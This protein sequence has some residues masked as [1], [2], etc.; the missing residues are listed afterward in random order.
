M[1]DSTTAL[2][3]AIEGYS[4]DNRGKKGSEN[5]QAML[6]RVHSSLKGG[7]GPIS[8][9][10]AVAQELAGENANRSQSAEKTNAPG[11]KGTNE[12]NPK[13]F[14]GFGGKL[15]ASNQEVDAQDKTPEKPAPPGKA[16]IHTSF[17]SGE[18]PSSDA[19]PTEKAPPPAPDKDTSTALSKLNAGKGNQ[20]ASEADQ[21]YPD[22]SSRSDA[23]NGAWKV[24][25]TKAKAAIKLGRNA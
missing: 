17:S 10:K 21:N 11:D 9:G 22:G 14:T 19:R 23:V 8:P 20:Q 12:P 2:L 4:K 15:G 16:A 1:A 7:N 5:T 13:A 24:A 25:S 6:D 18:K 3:S